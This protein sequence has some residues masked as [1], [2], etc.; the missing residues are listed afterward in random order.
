MYTIDSFS[1]VLVNKTDPYEILLAVEFNPDSRQYTQTVFRDVI[2]ATDS[3]VSHAFN[4]I[5]LPEFNPEVDAIVRGRFGCVLMR[6]GKDLLAMKIGSAGSLVIDKEYA[7]DHFYEV[8]LTKGFNYIYDDILYTIKEGEQ[9]LHALMWCAPYEKK[10]HWTS[11][12]IPLHNTFTK[13]GAKVVGAHYFKPSVVV[14]DFGTEAGELKIQLT[15]EFDIILKN[16]ES[17]VRADEYKGSL[18][19]EDISD[20]ENDL[21]E[22]KTNLEEFIS[23]N[24]DERLKGLSEKIGKEYKLSLNWRSNNG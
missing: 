2:K 20:V 13:K 24:L 8:D 21:R 12:Y 1:K 6:A 15:S 17:C 4:Q 18:D 16:Y 23:K 10:P 11:S 14:M 9:G 5:P 7:K 22:A 19:P 3:T